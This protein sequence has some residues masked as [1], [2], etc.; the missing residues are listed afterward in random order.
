MREI[1]WH[2]SVMNTYFFAGEGVINQGEMPR[3]KR[4]RRFRWC[5]IIQLLAV[6]RKRSA[7]CSTE[8][9][10]SRAVI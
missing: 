2:Y 1:L 7:G 4:Y 8:V 3:L 5:V 6:E 10:A 9:S